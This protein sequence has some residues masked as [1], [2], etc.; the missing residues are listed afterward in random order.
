M[1]PLNWRKVLHLAKAKAMNN[2]DETDRTNHKRNCIVW[3]SEVL[4]DSHFFCTIIALCLFPQQPLK[5]STIQKSYDLYDSITSF[6]YFAQCTGIVWRFQRGKKSHIWNVCVCVKFQCK[7][8]QRKYSKMQGNRKIPQIGLWYGTKKNWI[9]TFLILSIS[10]VEALGVPKYSSAMWV[11][12]FYM[13][14]RERCIS[15][16]STCTIRYNLCRAIRLKISK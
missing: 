2:Q 5:I 7:K 12:V 16:C 10:S 13:Q 11:C 8:S 15:F 1:I 14:R 9:E 4:N 3:A 6:Q